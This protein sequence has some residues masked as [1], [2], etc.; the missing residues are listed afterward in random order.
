[1]GELF[2]RPDQ[3]VKKECVYQ[4]KS[5]GNT[6]SKIQVVAFSSLYKAK[7]NGGMENL[8]AFIEAIAQTSDEVFA[9]AKL[10]RPELIK[11]WEK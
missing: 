11:Q 5:P 2:K 3:G 1:M 6:K 7:R 8:Q 9:E 4:V 10:K